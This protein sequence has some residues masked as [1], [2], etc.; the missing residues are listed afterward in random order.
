MDIFHWR[1]DGLLKIDCR[2]F[3]LEQG[4]KELTTKPKTTLESWDAGKPGS[5]MG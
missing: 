1:F 2:A 5:L 3:K 4:I